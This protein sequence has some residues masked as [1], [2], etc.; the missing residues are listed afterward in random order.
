MGIIQ[1]CEDAK[2]LGEV[3]VK[4][5]LPKTILKN[6]GMMTTVVGSILEKAGTMENLL[7]RIPNVSAQNGSIKV[8]AYNQQLTCP[9]FHLNVGQTCPA[10]SGT[11]TQAYRVIIPVSLGRPPLGLGYGYPSSGVGLPFHWG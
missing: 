6:G 3:V 8:F 4:S 10:M 7:D 1:L 9:H 5:S 11:S 2:M